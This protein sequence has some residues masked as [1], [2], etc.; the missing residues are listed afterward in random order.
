MLF[1][2]STLATIGGFIGAG[3]TGDPDLSLN[4]R[5]DATRNGKTTVD[6]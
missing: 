3:L 2:E 1:C 6:G 5:T 4:D